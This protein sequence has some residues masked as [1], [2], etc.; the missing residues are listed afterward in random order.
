MKNKTLL[1]ISLLVLLLIPFS[2]KKYIQQQE[3]NA[4]VKL[5]TNGT[6]RITGY[7]DHQV[8][9]LTDSF[10]GYSFQFNQNGTLY[11][12]RYGQQ[13]NGTWSA[14]I[15]NK[16]ITSSFPSASYPITLLNH[17]WTITDS[18]TDSVAA[19]TSVDSSYNILNLHKN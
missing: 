10:A 19:K 9:N 16:T 11:G 13:S 18:Y 2:C 5:V 14:D 12:T 1:I 15:N 17:T 4:L 6:W 3:Q 7:M 8:T